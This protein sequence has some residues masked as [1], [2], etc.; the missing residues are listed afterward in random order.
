M[1]VALSAV[2]PPPNKKKKK[3]EEG[4]DGKKSSHVK[5]ILASVYETLRTFRVAKV[6]RECCVVDVTTCEHF[7]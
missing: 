7:A 1:E 5:F 6:V 4:C 2:L 3:K